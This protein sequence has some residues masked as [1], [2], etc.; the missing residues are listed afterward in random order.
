[1]VGRV[2]GGAWWGGAWGEFRPWFWGVGVQF[3]SVI[4]A[5]YTIKKIALAPDA[6]PDS[7]IYIDF[8]DLKHFHAP[9][10]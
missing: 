7:W 2:Q 10:Y 5:V 3:A 9:L 1:M 6:Y 4:R 8:K